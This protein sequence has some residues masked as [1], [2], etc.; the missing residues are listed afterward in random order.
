[1]T[2][3]WKP[4]A[5][6]DEDLAPLRPLDCT[7]PGVACGLFGG[8]PALACHAA[9]RAPDHVP[10]LAAGCRLVWIDATRLAMATL[11]ALGGGVVVDRLVECL[12]GCLVPEPLGA[13]ATGGVAPAYLPCPLGVAAAHQQ[14][15]TAGGQDRPRMF[16]KLFGFVSGNNPNTTCRPRRDTSGDEKPRCAGLF[17]CARVDSNHHGEISPQGPQPCA[18][19]NSATGAEGRVYPRLSRRSSL[20][21][22]AARGSW[23]RPCIRPHPALQCEHVFVSGHSQPQEGVPQ[24]WI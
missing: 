6:P 9:V 5:P 3:A 18:S 23:V 16:G 7:A 1:V 19:T 12:R 20:C 10:P 4:G 13:L 8:E 17:A 24:T 2:K 15:L 14:L 22:P 21:H 11:A